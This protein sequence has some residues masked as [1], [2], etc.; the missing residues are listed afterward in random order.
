[1]RKMARQGK[2][3]GLWVF[4]CVCVVSFLGPD[5]APAAWTLDSEVRLA[6]AEEIASELERQRLD[7]SR[8]F[9]PVAAWGPF[10]RELVLIM[11]R[12]YIQTGGIRNS[13]GKLLD[14]ELKRRRLRSAGALEDSHVA[15]Y[16]FL[17]DQLT[18][19]A[20]R[21]SFVCSEPS[22]PSERMCKAR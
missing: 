4:I 12:S 7:G 22:D 18:A 15:D 14:D 20:S 1:M 3:V 13:L 5:Q 19:L 10:A 21:D 6:L 8:Y 16:E 9:Q 17:L 11:I 2:S